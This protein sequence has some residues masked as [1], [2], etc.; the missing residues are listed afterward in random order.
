MQHGRIWQQLKIA[1]L[2]IATPQFVLKTLRPLISHAD[3]FRSRVALSCQE[4]GQMEQSS[5]AR[6]FRTTSGFDEFSALITA[7]RK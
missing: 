5:D 2:H 7:A 1:Q 6:L 3:S 4:Q